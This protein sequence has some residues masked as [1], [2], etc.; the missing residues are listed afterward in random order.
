MLVLPCRHAH[1]KTLPALFVTWKRFNNINT[2]GAM[3][4][5]IGY[6]M[7][8]RRPASAVADI[9]WWVPRTLLVAG[10]QSLI[11]RWFRKPGPQPHPGAR[12]VP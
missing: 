6:S 5:N 11:F 9:P 12:R 2:R 4:M 10:M 3:L 7:T 8:E 1:C